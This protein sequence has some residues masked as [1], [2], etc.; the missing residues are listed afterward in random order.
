MFIIKKLLGG[1]FTIIVSI[2]LLLAIITALYFDKTYLNEIQTRVDLSL[3][4]AN[5]FYQSKIQSI[6]QM[7]N[8]LKI[9]IEI[10][11]LFLDGRLNFFRKILDRSLQEMDLDILTLLND[12][13]KVLY[14]AHNPHYNNDSLLSFSLVKKAIATGKQLSGPIIFPEDI[15]KREGDSLFNRSIVKIVNTKE[16]IPTNRVFE[17]NALAISSIVPIK[18]DDGNGKVIGYILGAKILN[19]YNKMVDDIKEQIFENERYQGTDIGTVTIFLNDLRVATNVRD[20]NGERAIGSLLSAKVYNHVL[21]NGERWVGSAFVV[22][23]HYITA[24]EPIKD[25]DNKIIGALYVGLLQKPYLQPKL[26]LLIIF[27]SIFLAMIVISSIIS[28]LMTKSILNPI[29]E[30]L[31]VLNRI[32]SGDLSARLSKQS[33]KEFVPLCNTINSMLDSFNKREE[34]LKESTNAQLSQSDKLAT[35]GR[36][37][38]GVAHE[39]N[40]PLTGVLTF[41]HLLREKNNM[42]E[43]DRADLDV[44]IK[45]TLRVREITRGLLDFSRQS[46][47]NKVSLDV[48]KIIEQ[49]KLLVQGHKDFKRIKFISDLAP[50]LKFICGD[51]NQIQQVIL[52]LVLN[53]LESMVEKVG[54]SGTLEIITA[55]LHN[56]IQIKIKDTGMGIEKENLEQIFEPFY[57]TKPVGMGTGLGLSIVY[58]NVNKHSGSIRVESEINVGTTFTLIFPTVSEGSELSEAN[59]NAPTISLNPGKEEKSNCEKN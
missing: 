4:S 20:G 47:S 21:V 40:N 37:S 31:N 34:I 3:N 43:E 29:E 12:Q 1:F 25:I 35:I 39:V 18:S 33:K 55:N 56:E 16:A 22:K 51:K 42:T 7:L 50:D 10:R 27:L 24:Y 45:E 58:G 17:K 11:K 53:A 26:Y 9:K 57:T 36:L 52:N 2:N 14:R 48:N 41:A 8:I 23:D 15:L 38:A 19:S 44:I 49:V 54:E 6:S 30:I 46:P 13:G 5:Y 59:E 32:M 28:Y